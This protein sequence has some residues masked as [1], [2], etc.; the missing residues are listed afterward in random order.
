MMICSLCLLGRSPACSIIFFEELA[1]VHLSQ[2][3]HP[4]YCLQVIQEVMHSFFTEVMSSHL[5]KTLFLEAA[6]VPFFY[7]FFQFDQATFLDG[8]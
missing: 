2:I 7:Q 8:P 5:G 4:V 6:C 3:P 1:K